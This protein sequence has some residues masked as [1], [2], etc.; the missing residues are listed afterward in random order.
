M[1]DEGRTGDRSTRGELRRMLSVA[2]KA[3]KKHTRFQKGPTKVL[4]EFNQRNYLSQLTK[5]ESLN[6]LKCC[7]FQEGV[8]FLLRPLKAFIEAN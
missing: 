8:K 4:I 6:D 3:E 1:S 5:F 2:L 7:S